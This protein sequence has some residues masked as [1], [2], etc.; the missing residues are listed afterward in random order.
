M[1]ENWMAV[2]A[3]TDKQQLAGAIAARV[4][5]AGHTILECYG[6]AAV[7]TAIQVGGVWQQ[8]SGGQHQDR[9]SQQDCQAVRQ[10]SLMGVGGSAA[11]LCCVCRAATGSM[12][13]SS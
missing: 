8:A 10:D 5:E 1:A 7:T 9:D 11:A 2:K 4:R 12:G 13:G 6:S 3:A